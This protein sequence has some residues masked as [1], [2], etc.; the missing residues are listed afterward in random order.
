MQILV[1]FWVQHHFS[2]LSFTHLHLQHLQQQS[3]VSSNPPWKELVQS[4]TSASKSI[5]L[6]YGTAISTK[7]LLHP[8]CPKNRVWAGFC[9][10][11]ALSIPA[12]CNKAQGSEVRVPQQA[13][14]LTQTPWSPYGRAKIEH[15]YK[16]T[17]FSFRFNFIAWHRKE[18]WRHICMT[19]TLHDKRK[20]NDECHINFGLCWHVYLW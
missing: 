13:L 8:S 4:D 6:L 3:R 20:W 2:N 14:V 16:V 7:E 10:P 5:V 18:M 12:L 17:L 11:H 15:A 9:S 1:A 19:S